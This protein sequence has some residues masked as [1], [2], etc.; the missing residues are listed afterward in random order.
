MVSMKSSA[1][2]FVPGYSNISKRGLLCLHEKFEIVNCPNKEEL[3]NERSELIT[4]CRHIN[5][6]LLANS[7]SH[8]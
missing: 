8:N 6:Y 1:E 2:K 5:K 4:K 3:L 7:K